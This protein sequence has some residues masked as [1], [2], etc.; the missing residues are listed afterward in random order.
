MHTYEKVHSLVS[1]RYG[2]YHKEGQLGLMPE[3]GVLNLY[4][5]TL[6]RSS[7]RFYVTTE[8]WITCLTDISQAQS[9]SL[10]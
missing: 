8:I 5:W 6:E 9:E 2:R 4:S 10:G 1:G 7:P 3:A